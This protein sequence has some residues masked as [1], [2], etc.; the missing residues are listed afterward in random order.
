V[1]LRLA[2]ELA[3]W[4]LRRR[5]GPLS[6]HWGFDR[7]TP[8][9]RWYIDRFLESH[10]ADIRGDVLEIGDTRYTDRWGSGVRSSD[11]LDATAQ[12]PETVVANLEQP[13][14]VPEERYD[15]LIVTQVLQYIFDLDAAVESLHRALRPGGV[16]LVTVPVISRLDISAPYKEY[17]LLTDESARRLFER[18]FSPGTLDVA[19]RGNLR[20]ALLFLL[21]VASDEVSPVQLRGDLPAF[22]LILTV[23]AV[24]HA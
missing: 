3:R 6:A 15:C 2:F 17:W 14:T 13:S 5:P 10:A 9:D 22:P 16:C 12:N 7:G 4:T 21:G 24:K 18:R 11:V 20:A 23:R 19:M 8:I 1:R